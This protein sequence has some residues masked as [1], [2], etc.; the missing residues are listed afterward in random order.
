MKIQF[1]NT[2]GKT[3][4]YGFNWESP[5]DKPTKFEVMFYHCTIVSYF[6]F[7]NFASFSFQ[8]VK[9]AGA[10]NAVLTELRMRN[11]WSY[12]RMVWNCTS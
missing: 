7:T 8:P 6:N 1:K 11:L 5:T 4:G 10:Q 9:T 3:L 2:E 12:R